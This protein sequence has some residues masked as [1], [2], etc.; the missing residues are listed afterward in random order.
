[1]F[2]RILT[3]LLVSTLLVGCG[4]DSPDSESAPEDRSATPAPT[5]TATATPSELVGEWQRMTTCQ[6]RVQA[7][8]E[9][10][11]GEFAAEHAAGEG[12][13]PGVTSVDQLKDPKKPCRGAV[14]LRHGHFFTADGLFGSRDADGNQV[15]D[16]TYTLPNDRSV[17]V[18]KEFGDVTFTFDIRD[19]KLFLTPV[20]PDCATNGCFAAQWAVAVAYPGLP[21]ERTE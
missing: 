7:L 18:T 12:W 21:W 4:S 1:M 6:Q 16:G 17:V 9:A 20:L 14:P 8:R 19:D 11:L 13:I 3:A 15:D 10:G 5:T 2:T